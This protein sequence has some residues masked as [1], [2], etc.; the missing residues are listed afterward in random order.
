M[1]ACTKLKEHQG[2]AHRRRLK[3]LLK[4]AL[5]GRN[6]GRQIAATLGELARKT[7]G[8]KTEKKTFFFE[9]FTEHHSTAQRGH[10]KHLLVLG[11]S[12]RIVQGTAIFG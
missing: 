11:P 6:Q 8:K 9:K 1:S 5:F 7:R 3:Q 12:V 10:L 4:I 2:Q